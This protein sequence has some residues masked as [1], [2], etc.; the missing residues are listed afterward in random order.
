MVNLHEIGGAQAKEWIVHRKLSEFQSL[1]RKLSEVQI[2]FMGVALLSLQTVKY[3]FWDDWCLYSQGNCSPYIDAG[4]KILWTNNPIA[5]LTVT[6][7]KLVELIIKNF[8]TQII[9]TNKW[10]LGKR[11][12]IQSI[13]SDSQGMWAIVENPLYFKPTQKGECVFRFH[14]ATI[15]HFHKIS[16]QYSFFVLFGCLCCS[17]WRLVDNSWLASLYT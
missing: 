5:L 8:K 3:S 4:T 1:H 13:Y 12:I 9:F 15:F 6:I 11:H 17:A 14:S 16:F 7:I 10:Y 2:N